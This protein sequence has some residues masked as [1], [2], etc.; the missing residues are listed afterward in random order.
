MSPSTAATEGDTLFRFGAQSCPIWQFHAMPDLHSSDAS[1]STPQASGTSKEFQVAFQRQTRHPKTFGVQAML[2]TQACAAPGGDNGT[3]SGVHVASAKRVDFEENK[4]GE[5]G[6]ARDIYPTQCA[7]ECAPVPKLEGLGLDIECGV[8]AEPQELE[9]SVDSEMP[10]ITAQEKLALA[11]AAVRAG[12]PDSY[13]A[14]C[15]VLANL[16]AGHF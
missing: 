4:I 15:T 14:F 9:V 5:L 6:A 13:A 12:K 2:R 1:V 11:A 8:E 7:Y 3:N 16:H 10:L